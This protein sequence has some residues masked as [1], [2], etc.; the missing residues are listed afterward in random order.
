MSFPLLPFSDL[1]GIRTYAK[2][3]GSDWILNGSKV[4][5]DKCKNDGWM[6]GWTFENMSNLSE[7]SGSRCSSQTVGWPMW[8]W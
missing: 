5:G 3:D 1:Q 6:D 4:L 2:R 8:W 7:V